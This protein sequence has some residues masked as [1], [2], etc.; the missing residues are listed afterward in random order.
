MGIADWSK[1]ETNAQ[2]RQL[3]QEA[4]ALDP[5]YAKLYS[6]LGWTHM[7]DERLGWSKSSSQSKKQALE[8]AYKANALDENHIAGSG[9]LSFIYRQKKEYEKAIAEAEKVID[10]KPNNATAYSYLAIVTYPLGRGEEAITVIEKGNSSRPHTTVVLFLLVRQS[11]CP[12]GNI[13]MRQLSAYKDA[14]IRDIDN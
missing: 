2:A 13:I 6:L 1:K 11:V 7:L 4:I 10:N 14:L 5:E 9:L 8:L 3:Y 12:Y